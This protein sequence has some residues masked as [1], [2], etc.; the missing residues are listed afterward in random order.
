MA[1]VITPIEVRFGASRHGILTY[2]THEKNLKQ[3]RKEADK[4]LSEF[5][6]VNI[7]TDDV[8]WNY[9]SNMGTAHFTLKEVR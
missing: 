4:Y 7:I 3:Q 5:F 2:H 1:N 6:N 9:N 8:Y